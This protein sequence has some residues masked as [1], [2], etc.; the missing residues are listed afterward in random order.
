M[1]N[2][3]WIGKYWNGD[4]DDKNEAWDDA[5][6]VWKDTTVAVRTMAQPA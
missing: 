1:K 2:R 6:E 5:S 3:F 4:L